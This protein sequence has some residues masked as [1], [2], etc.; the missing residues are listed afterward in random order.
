MPKREK[1]KWILIQTRIDPSQGKEIQALA[2]REGLPASAYLRRLVILHL[3]EMR[4][5]GQAGD[6]NAT[7]SPA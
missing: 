7:A 6:S 4:K 3:D 1:R 5:M 2:K